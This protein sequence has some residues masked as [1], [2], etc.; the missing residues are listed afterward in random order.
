M[1]PLI[2]STQVTLAVWAQ[3]QWKKICDLW[4]IHF[5]N[6]ADFALSNVAVDALKQITSTMGAKYWEFDPDTCQVLSVGLSPQP[7][8]G[9]ESSVECR[10]NFPND[11]LCHVVKMYIYFWSW[12]NFEHVIIHWPLLELDIIC[13][14]FLLHDRTLKRYSLPGNLPPELTR[15]FYLKEM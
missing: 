8:D 13:F 5:V 9:A 1:L 7:L 14:S 2:Y 10:C 15:L 11:T 12:F 4:C 3:F 6:V